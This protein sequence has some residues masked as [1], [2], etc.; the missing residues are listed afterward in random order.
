MLNHKLGE[1]TGKPIKLENNKCTKEEFESM[2]IIDKRTYIIQQEQVETNWWL[3]TMAK[4]NVICF[5]IALGIGALA[6]LI[7]ATM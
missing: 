3:R 5:F 4:I 2:S 7:K 1:L 6:I